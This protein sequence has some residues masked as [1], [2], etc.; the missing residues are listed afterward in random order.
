[1]QLKLQGTKIASFSSPFK[2]ISKCHSARTLCPVHINCLYAL[3]IV[4]IEKRKKNP[5]YYEALKDWN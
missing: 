3:F 5:N 1:M 2:S 4:A